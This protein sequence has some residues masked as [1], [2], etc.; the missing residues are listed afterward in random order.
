MYGKINIQ[1]SWARNIFS[2]SNMDFCM[3]ESLSVYKL[4]FE[5]SLA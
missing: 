4:K 3:G 1:D 5:E 2:W